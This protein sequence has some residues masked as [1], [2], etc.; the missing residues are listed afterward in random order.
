[1]SNSIVGTA[2]HVDHGKTLLIK[3]LTGMDTDRLAEEKKRGITIELGFAYLTLPN[4]ERAGIVDVPGHE[5]FVR[6]MLAGA[7]SIDL[8]MLVVAA[9]EGIMPQ[10]REHLAILKTLGIKRGLVALNKADLVEEDWLAMVA[11]DIEEELR[12]SFLEG[13]PIMAVSAATGQGIDSLR[14]EIFAML[15]AAPPKKTGIPFRL[16]IDRAFT[17][18]GFGT[19]V[20]GT[21]IE[22]SLAL[23][24][25]VALYPSGL[26]AKARRIHVHGD[27]VERAAAGQRVA[28]NL[29]GLKVSDISKGDLVAQPDSLENSRLLDVV[30][31]IDADCSREIRHNSRLHLYHGTADMLC[32][33]TL[34]DRDVISP[35]GRAYA[36]LRLAQPLAAK[37]GDRFVLRFY[38]PMETVGG[39]II[40]DAVAVRAKR[41]GLA[42]GRLEIKE[43]GD[44]TQRV[45]AIFAERSANFPNIEQI[46]RR[47]FLEEDFCGA[48]KKL[49][50]QGKLIVSESTA[51]HRDYADE[52]G[53]R[54][55]NILSKYHGENPLHEGMAAPEFYTRLLPH[56]GKTVAENAVQ[57]LAGMG[58]VRKSGNT[59]AHTNFAAKATDSHKKIADKILAIYGEAGFTTPTPEEVAA[60][61]AK[62]KRDF[63]QVFQSLIK[64]GEVVALTPQIHIRKDFFEQALQIF[65]TLAKAKDE[66]ALADFRDAIAASRKYALALLEYF[67]K[68]GITKKVGEGRIL[69]DKN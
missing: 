47:Y 51:V 5:R 4:G 36:Q 50:E 43:K 67:D 60:N 8:A 15:A 34:F 32:S 33:L 61:F 42:A 53:K 16:P 6:N 24:Q 40:L 63:T 30:I 13:A 21:L 59:I 49:A 62:E 22:G 57:S 9:D 46:R 65:I 10:T 3:A 19:V 1:M 25:D 55:Q 35:G 29:A 27:E 2:G 56:V 11:L 37:T 44:L 18:G 48:L 41:D 54:A 52:L 17:M 31:Q 23:G 20:T 26:A 45:A 68:K 58:F 38:S 64:R 12:G 39:G 28:V 66:V 7:G 69:L 14:Q